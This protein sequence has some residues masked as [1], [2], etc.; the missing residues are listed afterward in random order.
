MT[1]RKLKIETPSF[2]D[3]RSAAKR[4]AGHAVLTPLLESDYLNNLVGGRLLIKA[5]PLQRTGSFKFRGAF[6]ALSQIPVHERDKGV[7]AFSSGN[8]A[9]GVAC[10]AQLL[11]IPAKIIMPEDAPSLKIRNTR[12]YGAEVILYDRYTQDREAIGAEIA[13]RN[14]STLVKP[15]DDPHVIAGQG[16]VG[17]EITEQ[18]D[19]Q[20]DQ[21]ICCVGGGGLISGVALAIKEVYRD[22]A[23]FASEPIGFDSMG[24]SLKAGKRVGND[25][26]S[27]T[28]C[29]A[30]MPPKPGEYTFAIGYELLSGGLSVSDDQ[31]R[32]A[33]AKAFLHL[34]LVVEPGG[35]VALAAA[36]DGLLDCKGKTTI[37]ICSGGNVDP[38][39]FT[40]VLNDYN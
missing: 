6:N 29:D 37:I 10:A 9:Q 18:L 23:V 2:D 39:F 31:V 20:L 1:T 17:L 24:R 8:H 15:Y 34:K 38:K 5:E 25:P 22:A 36:L 35:I 12:S 40:E 32:S 3:I 13:E 21:V 16:T 11:G 33:M 4:I 14:G 7:V 28:I 26:N 30:L 27:T 19:N